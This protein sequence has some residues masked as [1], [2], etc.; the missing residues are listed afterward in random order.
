M[1]GSW[2]LGTSLLTSFYTS[3]LQVRCWS[4]CCSAVQ[5]TVMQAVLVTPP[6]SSPVNSLAAVVRSGLPVL[7]FGIGAGV[8][9]EWAASTHPDIRDFYQVRQVSAAV[10]PPVTAGH[11]TLQLQHQVLPFDAGFPQFDAVAAGEAVFVDWLSSAV[12][13]QLRFPSRHTHSKIH[14]ARL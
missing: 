11:L 12:H 7:M 5:V 2:L 14:Q 4:V 3:N 9:T 8:E 1:L 6:L 10:R 13:V